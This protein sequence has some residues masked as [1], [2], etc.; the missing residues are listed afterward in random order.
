MIEI[1]IE[2]VDDLYYRL[3]GQSVDP[4][5]DGPIA[6]FYAK[7]NFLKDPNVCSCKKGKNEVEF[8]KKLYMNL[9][10]QVRFDPLYTRIKEMLGNGILV[11]KID[12]HEI[13]RLK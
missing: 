3:S 8:V 12:G 6:V 7:A 5:K 1:V 4:E 9:P 10:S 11:F 2:G 13:A